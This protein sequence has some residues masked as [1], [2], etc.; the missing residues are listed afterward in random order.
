MLKIKD[1]ETDLEQGNYNTLFEKVYNHCFIKA[2]VVMRGQG[3]N[4]A[5]AKDFFQE[6]MIDFYIKIKQKSTLGITKNICGFFAKTTLFKWYN[7]LR[8]NKIKLTSDADEQLI[9]LSDENGKEGEIFEE[10][11]RQMEACI[12]TLTNTYQET[13]KAYYFEGKQVK[14]IAK[15]AQATESAI[16]GRLFDGRKKIQACMGLR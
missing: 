8:A 7:H 11:F 13:L 10:R 4:S 12:D 5:D 1:L 16:K 3:G 15:E 14:E 6:A 2:L 9:R